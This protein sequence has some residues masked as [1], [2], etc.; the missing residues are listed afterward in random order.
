MVN[1]RQLN[2]EMRNIQ[3]SM[4]NSQREQDLSQFFKNVHDFSHSS[5]TG[6]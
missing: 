3:C 5:T 6:L 1:D 2:I 4:S